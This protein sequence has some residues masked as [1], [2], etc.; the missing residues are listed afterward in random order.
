MLDIDTARRR[1]AA[2]RQEQVLRFWESLDES[3]RRRLLAQVELLDLEWLDRVL[4]QGGA[5]VVDPGEVA[6]YGS[7]IRE[8]DPDGE[9]AWR[10]GEQALR[11]GQVATL[12]VAG[13]QGTRLGFDGP[14][15]LFPAGAVS[16]RSLYQIHIE[17][18]LALGRRYQDGVPP[19][20]YIMTSDANH[21]QT[22]EF[23]E[24]HDRF[25]F[26][27]DRLRVFQQGLAPAVD[28]QGR[29]LLEAPDRLV[30]APNGNGG[31]FAALEQSGALEHMRSLDIQ[32][33]SYIQVDNPLSL[34]GDPRFVGY[35]LLRGSDFSCKAIR[36][37]GSA[38]RVGCYALVRGRLRVVEYTEI[39]AELAERTDGRGELLFLFANPGL[40][41]WSRDFLQAQARRRDLPFHFAHKKVV[42]L[43]QAGRLVE[44]AVPCAYK[45]EAFAMDTLPDAERSLVLACERDAEFAPIKNAAGADSPASARAL[46]T[47]LFS[48]WVRAAGG[49]VELAA[50]AHL[51]VSPLYALDAGE[52]AAKLP[53]GFTVDGPTFLR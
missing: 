27:G 38:E 10:R 4:A 37:R 24:R 28:E 51:E 16:G 9:R 23:L 42:H 11:Q 15:G 13:G 21:Q 18:Q 47:Q 5:P 50:D 29:L 45:L 6:P 40:F 34:S 44:P 7:V 25:G 41:L 12:L 17:R 52:L 26:P 1:L 14:K 22:L 31:L 30:L 32:V 20:L 8:D 43:D 49:R 48:G 3:G 46:M 19:P 53:A 35:H 33:L 39:P 36:K 2:H